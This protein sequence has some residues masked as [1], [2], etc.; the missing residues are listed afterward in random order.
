MAATDTKAARQPNEVT[1]KDAYPNPVSNATQ[2]E[3]YLPEPGPVKLDLINT[4]GGTVKV[5][6]EKIYPAGWHQQEFNAGT[7]PGGVYFYRLQTVKNA[8]TKT[9]ILIK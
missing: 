7:L 2:I 1:L 6:A 5:L 3:F 8:L 4:T 9:L